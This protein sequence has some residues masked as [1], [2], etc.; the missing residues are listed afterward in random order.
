MSFLDDIGGGLSDAGSWLSNLFGSSSTPTADTT[1]TPTDAS[2]PATPGASVLSIADPS[3]LNATKLLGTSST[4]STTD[5]SNTLQTSPTALTALAGGGAPSGSATSAAAVPGDISYSAGNGLGSAAPDSGGAQGGAQSSSTVQSIMKAL[6]L[7]NAQGGTNWGALAKGALG[8]GG[9]AY[10]VV[11]NSADSPATKQVQQM[12]QS[13]NAQGQKLES[14]LSNG[15]LPPGAQ[16]Y[17][18]QQVAAQKASI[19]SKY[20]A[21]GMSGSTAEAQELANVSTQAQSQMFQIASQLYQDGVSQTGASSNL[22][23]L[24]MDQQNQD[25]TQMG[26][27]ISNFVSSLGGGGSGGGTTIKIGG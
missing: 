4:P 16:Q 27:A 8:A 25:N 13:A 11:K 19:L 21:M 9:L 23:K 2:S 24:L 3:T 18:D 17:V 22:Y 15:T 12:A 1:S 5:V 26:N 20:A 10:D 14:Y 6:G 7:T